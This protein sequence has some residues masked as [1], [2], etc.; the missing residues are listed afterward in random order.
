MVNYDKMDVAR[1]L[2]GRMCA[3]ARVDMRLHPR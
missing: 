1:C 2:E 3:I